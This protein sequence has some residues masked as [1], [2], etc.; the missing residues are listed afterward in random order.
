MDGLDFIRDL[1]GHGVVK[2]ATLRIDGKP[3]HFSY[4]SS[5]SFSDWIHGFTGTDP[6]TI[7]GIIR[8][9]KNTG[10]GGFKIVKGVATPI[11]PVGAPRTGDRRRSFSVTLRSDVD[12]W[13]RSHPNMA[14]VV[15]EAI[16]RAYKDSKKQS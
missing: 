11:G 3:H 14:D 5:R 1:I 13:L 10:G 2:N 15:R 16:D 8:L 9:A 7:D 4:N 12:E 6:A